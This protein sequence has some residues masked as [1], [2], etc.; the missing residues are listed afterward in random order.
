MDV[1][2][3]KGV[4]GTQGP[5]RKYLGVEDEDYSGRFRNQGL[6]Q[7]RLSLSEPSTPLSLSAETRCASRPQGKSRGYSGVFRGCD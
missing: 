5:Q 7:E 3:S 1:E 2:S 4:D 6:L